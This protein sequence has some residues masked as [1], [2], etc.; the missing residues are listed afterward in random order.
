M[1][2]AKILVVEDD[3]NLLAAL[4]YNLQKEGYDVVTAA[5]GIEALEAARREKP[6]VIILDV[7]LPGINGFEVC[8]IL[9][10][11]QLMIYCRHRVLPDQFLCRYLYTKIA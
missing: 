5:D 6:G 1:S 3:R 9:R 11:N 2:T 7:M 8:H 10:V 4:K